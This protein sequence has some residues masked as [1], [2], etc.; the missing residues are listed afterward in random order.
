MT[1]CSNKTRVHEITWADYIRDLV[2][3][4]ETNYSNI[5]HASPLQINKIIKNIKFTCKYV[6]IYLDTGPNFPIGL[7]VVGNRP[8]NKSLKMSKNDVEAHCRIKSVTQS[9]KLKIKYYQCFIFT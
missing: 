8:D 5:I 2:Y 4:R 3:I 1:D 9:I 7:F 6:N